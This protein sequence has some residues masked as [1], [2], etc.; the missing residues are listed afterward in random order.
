M[1]ELTSGAG[2]SNGKPRLSEWLFNPFKYVAG[3]QALV[4]GLV[5]ILLAG[6]LGSLSN[7][8]FDGTLDFH[9]GAAFPLRVFLLEGLVDWLALALVLAVVGKA[10]SRT[11]FRAID[12][13]GTQAMAR[14]P[15]VF[16][17]SAALL[18]GYQR[19]AL[20]IVRQVMSPGATPPYAAADLAA[21]V[22]VMAV[23][24]MALVWMVALMYRSYS[25]CCNVRGAKGAWTFVIGV[26]AA[27]TVSKLVVLKFVMR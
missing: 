21:F 11:A 4:M 16:I 14:W 7:S 23:T 1:T 2:Q 19:V 3:M 18:P 6:F 15:T 9:N 24:L 27:E 13:F 5:A 12:L 10:V 22:L 20:T 26:L 25:L 17:A 8:H